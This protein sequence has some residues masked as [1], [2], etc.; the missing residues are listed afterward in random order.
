MTGRA[1][2]RVRAA[3]E[4]WVTVPLLAMNLLYK[5]SSPGRVTGPVPV[6]R[7][8]AVAHDR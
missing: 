3:A 4:Y 5:Q 1:V 6:A 7:H 8:T 2:R